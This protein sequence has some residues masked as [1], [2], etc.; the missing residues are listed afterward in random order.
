MSTCASME[1]QSKEMTNVN[2]SVAMLGNGS[3]GQT[4][5]D[6]EMLMK[7]VRWDNRVNPQ[8]DAR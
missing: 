8:S 5:V 2:Q 1:D 4:S 6:A 7:M 3:K